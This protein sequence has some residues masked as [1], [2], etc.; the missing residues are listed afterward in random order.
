[1][2]SRTGNRLAVACLLAALLWPILITGYPLLFWDS[3]EY[4]A[5]G[6]G[7]HFG[8]MRPPAYHYMIRLLHWNTSIW[9]IIF[10]Q[11]GLA[12]WLI[13]RTMDAMRIA[14]WRGRMGAA[15]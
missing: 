3:V 2:G 1:M 13:W 15:A 4:F 11:A 8:T 10:G 12:A 9:P 5:V 7:L 6:A 14:S